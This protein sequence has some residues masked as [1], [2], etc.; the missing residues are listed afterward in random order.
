MIQKECVR[1]N[2][3]YLFRFEEVWSKDARCK[4]FVRKLWNYATLSF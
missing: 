4:N 1:E 3:A 2:K